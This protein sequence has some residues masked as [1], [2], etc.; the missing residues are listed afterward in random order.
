[1]AAGLVAAMAIEQAWAQQRTFTDTTGRQIK[2]EMLGVEGDTARIRREDGQ[3]FAVPLAKLSEE[4]R[5]WV[6]AW[7]KLSP[8]QKK[9]GKLEPKL[10]SAEDIEVKTRRNRL[11]SEKSNDVATVQKEE[12]YCYVVTVKNNGRYP[13]KELRA[14][15]RIYWKDNF[16]SEQSAKNADMSSKAGDGEVGVIPAF[17][18]AEF[19]T[20]SIPISSVRLKEGWVWSDGSRRVEKDSVYG[21]WLRVYAGEEIVKELISPASITNNFKWEDTTEKE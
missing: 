21:L 4:D 20:K 12:R 8:E 11:S 13:T 16:S 5:Q 14:E 10:A 18:Q 17:G 2:A 7:R 3:V 15:Y 1:V 9:A 6:E 19:E